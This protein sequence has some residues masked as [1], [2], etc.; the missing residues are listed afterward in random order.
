MESLEDLEV[1]SYEYY[2]IKFVPTSSHSPSSHFL[3]RASTLL[4]WCG[5]RQII[6][7][8]EILVADI[9]LL[10]NAGE[11]INLIKEISQSFTNDQWPDIDLILS[12]FKLP[13]SDS[14]V[15]DKKV[16]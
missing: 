14:W 10:Q 5:W 9:L 15:G 1:F 4:L 11:R 13:T 6:T 7:E 8:E 12:E 3:A 2:C 16:M